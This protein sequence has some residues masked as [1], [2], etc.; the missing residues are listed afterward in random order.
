[1]IYHSAVTTHGHDARLAE[2]IQRLHLMLGAV[3]YII[4]AGMCNEIQK[5]HNGVIIGETPQLRF[6]DDDSL[7]TSRALDFNCHWQRSEHARQR[8]SK[9]SLHAVHLVQAVHAEGVMAVQ[10]FGELVH[11]VV[12]FST[13]Q[14]LQKRFLEALL[15]KD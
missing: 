1:M 2:E 13:D 3:L 5:L 4:L 9:L 10:H 15:V 14:A 12:H 6:G 11:F 7:A 8:L